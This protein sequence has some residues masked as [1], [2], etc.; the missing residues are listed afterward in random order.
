ME[1]KITPELLA[2]LATVRDKA[3]AMPKTKKADRYTYTPIEEIIDYLREIL[4]VAGL[5]VVQKVVSEGERVGVETIIYHLGGG[6]VSSRVIAPPSEGGLKMSS[7]QRAGAEI[8]YLRR[9]SLAAMLSLV[10]DP[11][12][13]GYRIG[14]SA[15]DAGQ[16]VV[17]GHE[18]ADRADRRA[19]LKKAMA[20]AG[21]TQ[22]EIDAVTEKT[23]SYELNQLWKK[24]CK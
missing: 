9:Y 19:Y 1:D 11:D 22:A 7:I 6:F 14:E 21:A 13:D 15:Q 16:K 12:T 18:D 17:V 24:Y 4:E 23:T 20:A 10:S 3:R 2:A 5:V 8:T